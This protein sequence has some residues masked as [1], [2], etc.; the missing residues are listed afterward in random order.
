MSYYNRLRCQRLI[1]LSICECDHDYKT[2]KKVPKREHCA[3]DNN[4]YDLPTKKII[5]WHFVAVIL[6]PQIAWD[7]PDIFFFAITL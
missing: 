2:V 4:N 6:V 7:P 5:V 1:C 3:F